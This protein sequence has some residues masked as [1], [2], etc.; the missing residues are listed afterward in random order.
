MAAS[1]FV[2]TGYIVACGGTLS[3]LLKRKKVII[4]CSCIWILYLSV[5]YHFQTRLSLVK[6]FFPFGILD[7]IG[8]IAAVIVVLFVS[9]HVLNEIPTVN[10]FL[11]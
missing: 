8:S 6:A 10:T 7:Y 11:A 9:H 2:A 3:D 1:I 5:T 4:S